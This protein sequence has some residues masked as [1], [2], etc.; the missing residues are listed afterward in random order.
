MRHLMWQTRQAMW[1]DR[2]RLMGM[3]LLGNVCAAALYR[4]PVEWE[5]LGFTLLVGGALS[6][7]PIYLCRPWGPASK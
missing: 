1:E 6:W 7:L 2:Y 3:A 4:W 5:R